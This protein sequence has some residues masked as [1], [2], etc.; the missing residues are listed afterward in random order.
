[1]EKYKITKSIRFKIVPLNA[2]TVQAKAHSLIATEPDIITLVTQGFELADLL[3]KYIYLDIPDKKLKNSVRVHFRW[4]RQ[5][6]RENWYKW[7]EDKQ[8]QK[9][10]KLKL[11]E[12]SYISDIFTQFFYGWKEVLGN[13]NQA[14]QADEFQSTRKAQIGLLIR[15]LGIRS[16]FLFLKSF[17]EDSDDK[18]SDVEKKNLII[19]IDKFKTL[20]TVCEKWSLPAQ[21]SGIELCRASFNYY[22]INK[23]PKD[24]DK[25]RS[26]IEKQLNGTIEFNKSDKQR[27][28][29][30]IKAET[31]TPEKQEFKIKFD[32]TFFDKSLNNLFSDLKNYKSERKKAFGEAV[33]QGLIYEKAKVEYPFFSGDED[34]FEKYVELT[35]QIT[36]LAEQKIKINK[37]SEEYKELA[38]KLS[39][40]RQFRGKL[41]FDGKSQHGEPTERFTKYIEYS[42]IYKEVAKKRGQLIAKLKGI[43][44]EEIDSQRLQYWALIL[45]KDTKHQLVLIPKEKSQ[46][47][48]R[49]VCEWQ[50]E[51]GGSVFIYYFES[52]TY[53]SLKILC[54]GI[55]GNTFLPE[56]KRELKQKGEWYYSDFNFGEHIFKKDD[57]TRDEQKLITFYKNILKTDYVKD[58]L[59]VPGNIYNEVINKQFE[60]E[61]DFRIQLEKCCYVRHK[62]ISGEKLNEFLNVNDAETFNI[63]SFDI[64]RNEKKN[65]EAHTLIWFNFWK[66]E[67][68]KTNFLIRLNPEIGINWREP[69]KSRLE[70]YGKGSEHYDPNKKNRYL[71][72]QFTLIT[73]FTENALTPEINY[74]FQDIKQKGEAI[75]SFNKKINNAFKTKYENGD[76]WFYGIDTGIIELA[77][78]CIMDRNKKPFKFPVIQLKKDKLNFEKK[79]FF[80]DGSERKEPYKALKNMS[81]FLNEELYRKTFRDDN[82]AKVYSELFEEKNECAIDLTWAKLI[83]GKIVLNGDLISSLNLKIL[84][85]KRKIIERLKENPQSELED[86]DYKIRFKND[87]DKFIY[88]SRREFE[89]IQSYKDIREDIF[90]YKE[91]VSKNRANLL[92]VEINNSRRAIVSNMVGIIFHLYSKYPAIICFE[93]LEFGVIESHRVGPQKS[94]EGSIERPLQWAILR[95]F[96]SLGLTPPVSELIRLRE[97]GKFEERTP[98]NQ[99]GI[100]CFVNEE[101]GSYCPNCPDG[102]RSKERSKKEEGLFIC[103]KCGYD[104]KNCQKGLEGLD[105]H[106]KIAAFN[107]AKLGVE[108]LK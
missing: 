25:E 102:R 64:E 30:L 100:V 22:T 20:L 44:K 101:Y 80:A 21:S 107:Y 48:Y 19:N 41:F 43:E 65:L 84:N 17:I 24:Y 7:I 12:V 104:N 105:D 96:Q 39:N 31:N 63:T 66:N 54:F 6:T 16:M 86:V 93:D 34:S 106:D 18:D 98:I 35:N 27:L 97:P 69:K 45:E 67:N 95:K 38:D 4:L 32:T 40:L 103:D 81:Y 60:T 108:Q 26:D 52:I 79:G 13:L 92:E 11:R 42:K 89:N 57:G 33:T 76:L 9:D 56:I 78:L 77:T 72:P 50:D 5:F 94:F 58:N 51:K 53:R 10:K 83:N 87:G 55:N 90:K 74:A 99:L 46:Q 68:E 2:K 70:K 49:Q 91:D 8:I 1:M 3:E 37:E 14:I 61:Q 23:K 73:S 15:K 71:S 29:E 47:G 75:I 62:K 88:H 28:S 85:A 36:I 82:F 59:K